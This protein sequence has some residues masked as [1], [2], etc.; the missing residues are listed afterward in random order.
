MFFLCMGLSRPQ[1]N[2]ENVRK[3][4]SGK[5]ADRSLQKQGERVVIKV[6]LTYLKCFLLSPGIAQGSSQNRNAEG[7]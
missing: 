1:D 5:G 3:V 2:K 4:T 6:A 7:C